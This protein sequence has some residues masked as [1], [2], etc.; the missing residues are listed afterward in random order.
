M[1]RFVSSL[2]ARIR[3]MI[4]SRV[5]QGSSP[6]CK[7]TVPN[8]WALALFGSG[9]NF[10]KGHP[11]TDKRMVIP[12]KAAIQAILGAE[13]GK[14]YDPPQMDLIAHTI[15]TNPVRCFKEDLLL[16]PFGGGKQ[17]QDIL[18]GQILPF[19]G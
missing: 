17:K 9:D 2:I 15:L 19:F 18:M 10:C 16:F 14:L 1:A 11:V 7:T 13:I 5:N 6:D 12:A 8:P 3:S 4:R